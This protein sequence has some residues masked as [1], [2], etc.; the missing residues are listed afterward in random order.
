MIGPDFNGN[1]GGLLHPQYGLMYVPKTGWQY[2]GDGG[3]IRDNSITV[4]SP[5]KSFTQEN[6]DPVIAMTDMEESSEESVEDDDSNVYKSESYT[7]NYQCG[8]KNMKPRPYIFGGEETEKN[9][10]PWMASIVN[11]TSSNLHCGAT[12]ISDSHLI[13]AAHCFD[14]FT[15]TVEDF[16]IR[17]GDHDMSLEAETRDKIYTIET[18]KDYVGRDTSYENDV[19]LI[20]LTEKVMFI[21][22]WPIC[23]PKP[24]L[25]TRKIYNE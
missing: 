3:W 6:F 17:L 14:N 18:L 11:V 25:I 20:K 15:F 9:K 24:G 12:L 23:L 19:A 4:L 8:I 1:A 7:M 10:W 21:N 5:R 13:T 22:I 2:A 16:V